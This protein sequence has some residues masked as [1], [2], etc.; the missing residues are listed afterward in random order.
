M[1]ITSGAVSKVLT[2]AGMERS[3]VRPPFRTAGFYLEDGKYRGQ[4]GTVYARFVG[5]DERKGFDADADREQA[6]YAEM[7]LVEAG[8]AVARVGSGLRVAA[9]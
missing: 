8:F 6:D 5:V 4:A 7:A 1:A 3:A 9:V 2:A